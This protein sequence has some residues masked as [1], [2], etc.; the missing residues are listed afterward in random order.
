MP[1]CPVCKDQCFPLKYENVPI[2]QCGT[3]GGHWVDKVKLDRIC[4]IRE[5]EMPDAVKQKMMDIA[6]ESN[7]AQKLWCLSCG[8][9]MVKEQFKYWDDIQIDRCPKC[10]RIWLDRGE[11][12]K[13][14]IYWEYMQDHPEEWE[15]KNLI[16]RKAL[17]D[18]EFAARRAALKDEAESA[19]DR[20]RSMGSLRYYGIANI[21]RNLFTR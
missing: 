17:L 9:E 11:L 15:G 19:R 21:L 4:A 10:N 5:V 7:S 3:C 20:A 18:A 13:C 12:E 2:F 8:T 6:D 14:Q 1:R 16:E